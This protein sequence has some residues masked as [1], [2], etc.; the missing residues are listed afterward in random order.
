M[1][2]MFVSGLALF[3]LALL[4]VAL[5]ALHGAGLIVVPGLPPT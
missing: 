4:A 5:L 2:L 1:K 3:L